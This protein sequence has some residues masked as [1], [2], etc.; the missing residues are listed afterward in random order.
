M[1]KTK[2]CIKTIQCR[3]INFF[4]CQ[5]NQFFLHLNS[6]Q[7]KTL[8][9][10]EFT[11]LTKFLSLMY[12]GFFSLRNS[13]LSRISAAKAVLDGSIFNVLKVFL[14]DLSSLVIFLVGTLL[15]KSDISIFV[16]YF[17]GR[18]LSC[19]AYLSFLTGNSSFV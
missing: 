16:Y 2:R 7:K 12:F 15:N 13:F 19:F 14:A 9:S 11:S 17:L 10:N 4:F 18:Y 5:Q 6:A 1:E 3:M 8:F